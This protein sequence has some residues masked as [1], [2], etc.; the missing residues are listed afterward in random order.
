MLLHLL[1][2][3]FVGSLLLEFLVLLDLLLFEL[4]AFLIL[5]PAQVVHLLLLALLHLRIRARTR[6]RRPI[7]EI[8]VVVRTIIR[9]R[10]RR[11]I[12][13]V[14]RPIVGLGL[15]RLILLRWPV[16]IGLCLIGRL[17]LLPW[18][19]H[20]RLRLSRLVG[21]VRPRGYALVLWWQLSLAGFLHDA[22]I[23]PRLIVLADLRDRHWAAAV[24]LHP[25]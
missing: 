12:L 9:L 25:L 17:V 4:L 15:G 20:V 18:T 11:L 19:V 5:L 21:L 2:M 22:N 1:L 8:P 3:L 23:I 7:V 16:W 24:G 14:G 6:R 10:L 13:L